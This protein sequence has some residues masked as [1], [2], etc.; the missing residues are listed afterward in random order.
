MF[1]QIVGGL[2]ALEKAGRMTRALLRQPRLSIEPFRE[3]ENLKIWRFL[4]P[5][6][7]L[8]KFWTL[9]IRLERGS[10]AKRCVAMARVHRISDPIGPIGAFELHWADVPYAF[11]TTGAD[12]VDIGPEGHRLDVAYSFP[13]QP[14]PGCFMA[15]NAALYAPQ[16]RPMDLLKP[17]KYVVEVVVRSENAGSAWL[18]CNLEA[19]S[20]W[21]DLKVWSDAR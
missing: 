2:S 17:G 8:R 4:S 9:E 21:T 3:S 10:L 7:A 16:L 18:T 13:E 6:E 12:P 15:T 11:R 19:G 1:E 5:Q 14:A 20:S